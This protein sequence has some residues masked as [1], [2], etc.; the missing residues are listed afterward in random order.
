M[1][2]DYLNLIIN[3]CI[4]YT[5]S[6]WKRNEWVKEKYKRRSIKWFKLS[7]GASAYPPQGGGW[8]SQGP[9]QGRKRLSDYYV[10][11]F[12]PIIDLGHSLFQFSWIYLI[13]LN[14]ETSD[15]ILMEFH[16]CLHGELHWINDNGKGFCE[17]GGQSRGYEVPEGFHEMA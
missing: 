15:E 11:Y 6:Y 10:G 13:L 17:V 4:K 12:T 9:P 5:K 3:I 16:T 1:N 2:M 8:R 7:R 14:S